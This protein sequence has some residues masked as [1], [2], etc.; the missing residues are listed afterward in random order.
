MF[1]PEEATIYDILNALSKHEITTR[2]LVIIYLNRI[3]ELDRGN[4]LNS[5]LSLNPDALFTADYLD[6]LRSQGRILGPLHGVPVMLKGNINTGDKMPTSAG[7]VALK[8]N[9]APEDAFIVK[10]LRE[11]GAL[12]LG[13]TNLTEFANFIT[14]GMPNGYSSLGKRVVNAYD[15]ELDPSGSSSGSGVAVSANLCAVAV[16]S[17]TSG[18]IMSPAAANG[19]VGLKPTMGLLSRT[20]IIPISNTLD[21]AGPMTRTVADAAVLLSVMA[22]RDEND[23]ATFCAPDSMDYSTYLTKDGIKGKRVGICQPNEDFVKDE[24][25]M[26]CANRV[27]QVLVEQGAEIVELPEMVFYPKALE[28]M[29]YEIADAI[30]YYLSKLGPSAPMKTLGDI[31]RFNQEHSEVALKYGQSHFLFAENSASGRM[32]E[33]EYIDVL[34]NKEGAI[35]LLSGLFKENM[36]DIIYCPSSTNIAPYTGYPSLSLPIGLTSLGHPVGSYFIAKPFD[37]GTLISVTFALEQIIN[38]RKNPFRKN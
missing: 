25:R 24:E 35:K 29:W 17:E 27:K 30:N 8:W 18:S 36:L 10:K 21:T 1:T 31:I 2:E 33:P 15:P 6:D 37:E 4:G 9:F 5:V 23:P 16:G 32:I 34:N 12:I 7:S 28:L 22:G 3:K 38:G 26:A 11:A 13:K 14:K 20:G 19:V